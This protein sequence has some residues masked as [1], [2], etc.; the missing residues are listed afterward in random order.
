MI[1]AA[2]CFIGGVLCPGNMTL[3]LPLCIDPTCNS[4]KRWYKLYEKSMLLVAFTI[5]QKSFFSL[6][7]FFASDHLWLRVEFDDFSTYRKSFPFCN[8]KQ[9]LLVRNITSTFASKYF[10]FYSNKLNKILF[11]EID[12]CWLCS[13]YLVD[14]RLDYTHKCYRL[15]DIKSRTIRAYHFLS[16]NGI[17]K[18]MGVTYFFSWKIGGHKNDW[19]AKTFTG[20]FV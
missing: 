5:V 3:L 10:C 18:K 9:S 19:V 4:N 14:D 8:R 13:P 2:C 15:C 20:N 11:W 6:T 16:N 17:M 12:A 7:T 1:R